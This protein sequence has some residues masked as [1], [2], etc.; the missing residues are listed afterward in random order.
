MVKKNS[1]INESSS[2]IVLK[3]NK[4]IIKKKLFSLL[5]LIKQNTKLWYT[6][7]A[8]MIAL[9]Q[10]RYT[11]N[12]IVSFKKEKVKLTSKI[13]LIH[14]QSKQWTKYF[15]KQSTINYIY[16]NLPNSTNCSSIPNLFEQS[17]H[18][19]IGEL[20][21]EVHEILDTLIRDVNT[22]SNH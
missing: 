1:S 3:P 22:E 14:L 10:Y 6:D 5:L 21:R 13:S 15:F 17:I 16:P 4:L 7:W 18:R 11:Q 19:F 2:K 12:Y 9:Y 8:R 20:N